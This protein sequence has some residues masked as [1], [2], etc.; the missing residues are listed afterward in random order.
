MSVEVIHT[1][2]GEEY[3]AWGSF[4]YHYSIGISFEINEFLFNSEGDEI[5]N[6]ATIAEVEEA[7]TKHVLKNDTDYSHLFPE[8]YHEAQAYDY[9]AECYERKPITL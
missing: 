5:T 3:T 4:T 2:K 6:I 9:R 8:E 1:Y 7:I